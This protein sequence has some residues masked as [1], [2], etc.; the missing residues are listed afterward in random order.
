M[1]KHKSSE[2]I[3][4]TVR[5]SL[6]IEHGLINERWCDRPAII[7]QS[8]YQLTLFLLRHRNTN[9]SLVSQL[10]GRRVIR[11]TYKC[12]ANRGISEASLMRPRPMMASF[13]L[14]T[15]KV[16]GVRLRDGAVWILLTGPMVWPSYD[17]F[18]LVARPELLA[19]RYL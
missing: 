19:L 5:K 10:L 12:S 9:R 6:A 11:G 4:N 7:V 18:V 13:R 16:T 17:S 15:L 3:Q 8:S 14:D 2:H 1:Y